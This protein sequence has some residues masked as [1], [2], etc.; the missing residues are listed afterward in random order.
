MKMTKIYFNETQRFDQWWLK[1]LM[2]VILSISLVPIY[3]GTILQL[4]TGKQFGNHPLNNQSLVIMDIIL[5]LIVGISVSFIFF[6]KLKTTITKTGITISFKPFVNNKTINPSDIDRW[7]VKK[8]NPIKD[9][10]GWG[11]RYGNKAKGTAYTVKGNIGLMLFL[12]NR[13]PVLIGTQ[14]PDAIKRVM[15]KLTAKA[16]NE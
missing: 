2:T 13:R 14:R 6:L 12:K 16:E 1:L 10:G 3:Y 8:Y 4:T 9:Y 15:E 5:T 11:V 7:E